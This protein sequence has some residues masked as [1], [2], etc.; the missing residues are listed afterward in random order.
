MKCTT[1][2]YIM[3]DNEI[4][5]LQRNKKKNDA[6]EG[7]W[8]GV[9]GKLQDHESPKDCLI[10]EVHE[11]TGF[12]LINPKLRGILT[13]VL[14]KWEDE[15]SFVYTADTF[16]GEL[17]E[18]SE[19]TLAWISKQNILSLPLWEGDKAFLPILLNEERFFSMKLIYDEN[20]CL[21]DV[22]EE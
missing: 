20:D 6:N 8:I 16:E 17:Q 15:L 3:R 9:G 12:K 22:I 10:R 13:F 11:E 14:P 19:G 18:C 7:K 21:V 4:L 2:C 1:L 5:L